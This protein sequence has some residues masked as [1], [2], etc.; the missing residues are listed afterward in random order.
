MLQLSAI[1]ERQEEIINRLE[2]RNL[3]GR[4]LVSQ[5]IELD[6][7]RKKTQQVLDTGLA[8][9]NSISK[10][11]GELFKAGKVEEANILKGKTTELKELN[12]KGSEAL[13]AVQEELTQL[14][15]TIPNTPDLS[16]TKGNTE[17][18]QKKE[19]PENK[20]D[21]KTREYRKKQK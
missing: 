7:R 9:A 4:E 12:H 19:K 15:Y 2:I 11:I 10:Q 6:D 16:V 1:R 5:I 3:N 8:D 20:K 17:E 13:H 18:D 14:L 21:E